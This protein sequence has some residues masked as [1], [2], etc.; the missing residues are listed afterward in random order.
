MRAAVNGRYLVQQLTGQQRYAREIVAR[1]ADRMDIVAPPAAL[2]GMRGHLWE[3]VALPRRVLGSLLWSPSTTGPLTV[4]RQVVTIHD[5]AFFDQA[6]CF[7]RA[8]VTWYQFL[9]P[10]LARLARRIVT[11]SN[12]SKQRIVEHCGVPPEKVAVVYS[13]VGAHFRPHSAD[14]IAAARARLGLPPRYVL[15]VG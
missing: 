13:G 4:R 3:Q 14:E 2:K 1:L 15:C 6:H 8:F 9:V 7:S 11:V 10:R 5:C 12:F